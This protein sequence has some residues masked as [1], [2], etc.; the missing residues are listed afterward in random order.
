MSAHI[1]KL[2]GPLTRSEEELERLRRLEFEIEPRYA[3][4][5]TN[6]L[7]RC[8]ADS[9]HWMRRGEDQTFRYVTVS[10]VWHRDDDPRLKLD[11]FTRLN[12]DSD[13]AK[14]EGE[15]FV[16]AICHALETMR[17]I[18]DRMSLPL[19][20]DFRLS[21]T[22][23]C[24]L[25][26]ACALTAH[27]VC[28]RTATKVVGD[29]AGDLFT[30]VELSRPTISD[31]LFE[32]VRVCQRLDLRLDEM[33]L[34]AIVGV[35]HVDGA[36]ASPVAGGGPSREVP[37]VTSYASAAPAPAAAAPAASSLTRIVSRYR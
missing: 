28:A 18:R 12:T 16:G 15:R 2:H 37:S 1:D 10:K 4:G 14:L 11:A 36:S 13:F 21:E 33:L 7:L 31:A 34:G 22:D 27:D 24:Y 5:R 17:S 32:T 6:R 8:C 23:A 3:D 9:W 20:S 26:R 29:I 25:V 19:S 35:D 30:I